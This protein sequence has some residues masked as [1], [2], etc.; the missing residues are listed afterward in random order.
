MPKQPEALR[1]AQALNDRKDV[2]EAA[3]A[4]LRRLHAENQELLEILQDIAPGRGAGFYQ[5]GKE[6][7]D[8]LT[9][10]QGKQP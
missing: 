1:L 4:E 10:S 5:R 7:F 9:K 8:H 3:A 2:Y 6:L